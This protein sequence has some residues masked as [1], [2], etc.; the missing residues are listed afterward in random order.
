MSSAN[1]TVSAGSPNPGTRLVEFLRQARSVERTSS[2]QQALAT[3]FA[4][5]NEN[6]QPRLYRR[7]ADLLDLSGSC[8]V[9]ALKV[10]ETHPGEVPE[11]GVNAVQRI[12]KALREIQ[13]HQ[14]WEQ[15]VNRF[16][17]DPV[18]RCQWIIPYY[19]TPP[20]EQELTDWKN[21]LNA[22]LKEALGVLESAPEAERSEAWLRAYRH[23][24]RALEHLQSMRLNGIEAAQRAAAEVDALRRIRLRNKGWGA[25]F[26]QLVRDA[27][28]ATAPV[29]NLV[30]I[31][32]MTSDPVMVAVA[33]SVLLVPPVLRRLGKGRSPRRLPRT[34]RALPPGPQVLENPDGDDRTPPETRH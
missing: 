15:T 12:D 4:I 24:S 17:D 30:T 23:V 25:T 28:D 16:G 20:A 14:Q 10:R 18:S 19:R 13:M 33:A 22:I 1:L 27:G 21:R 2:S 32:S 6:T 26:R 11:E 34:R 31:G 9:F 7:Y 29:A 8:A 3:I 5:D